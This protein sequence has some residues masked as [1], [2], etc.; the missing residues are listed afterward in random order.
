MQTSAPATSCASRANPSGDPVSITVE[1][2]ARFHI[3]KP[4]RERAGS[5]SAVST[6]TTSAP[7]SASSMAAIGPAMP[8]LRSRTRRP[9]RAW[10]PPVD[11]VSAMEGY[12]LPAGSK[13]K[14]AL[15]APVSWNTTRTGIPT[16]TASG[17]QPTM[18]VM[19][20]GPSSSST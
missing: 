1:R 2:L 20:R 16:R 15:P 12:A 9:S 3:A 17:S 5:P 13:R 6:F 8:M 10:R 7:K 14:S 4:G 19:T 11:R 18:L